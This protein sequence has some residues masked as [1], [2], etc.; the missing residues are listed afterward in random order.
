MLATMRRLWRARRASQV[1]GLRH[2]HTIEAIRARLSRPAPPS[3][4]ADAIY[5]GFDG[6]VTTFAVVAGVA[7]A[8]L[9]P[10]VTLILGCANLLGDGFSMAAGAYLSNRAEEQRYATLRDFERL[11]VAE[12]PEGERRE[13]RE[14]LAGMGIRDPALTSA[15]DAMTSTERAW[16]DLMLLGEYG[17]TRPRRTSFAAAITTFTAFVL[18]GAVPLLP[19]AAG[20][21]EPFLIATATTAVSFVGLGIMKA[22]HASRSLLMSVL[23]TLAVGSVSAGLAYGVGRLFVM[24]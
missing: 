3:N 19:F 18:F 6:T 10:T 9:S 14:I 13:I 11:S 23:E 21:P 22:R 17:L 20:L 2:E 16:V 24:F 15:T 5:G 8:S 1:S 4:A 12:T 7:G